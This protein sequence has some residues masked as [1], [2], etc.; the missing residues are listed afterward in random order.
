MITFARTVTTKERERIAY[1]NGDTQ[2]SQL[3]ADM[4]DESAEYD[5]AIR[6]DA[7]AAGYDK[8]YDEGYDAAEAEHAH[9]YERGN[10]R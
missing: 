10:T 7:E 4:L 5:E 2:L 8:G 9:A 1:A 6:A 3:L